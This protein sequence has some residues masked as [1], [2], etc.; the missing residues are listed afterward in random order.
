[1]TTLQQ[2]QAISIDLKRVAIAYQRGSVR[3]GQRFL[4]EAIKRK[5][6]IGISEIKPYIVQILEKLNTLSNENP[7]KIAEDTLVDSTIIQN[8]CLFSVEAIK[9]PLAQ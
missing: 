8:Y 5:K 2:L 1:M 3:M 6:E 9:T 7:Q 4:I